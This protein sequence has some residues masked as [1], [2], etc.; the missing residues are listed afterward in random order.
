MDSDLRSR[1][2]G[3]YDRGRYTKGGGNKKRERER[4]KMHTPRQKVRL[5]LFNTH[6]HTCALLLF[7]VQ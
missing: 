7:L 1:D 3:G 5:I 4:D 2:K 6:S